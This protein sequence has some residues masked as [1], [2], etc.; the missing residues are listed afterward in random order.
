MEH[1]YQILCSATLISSF[2][3]AN[4]INNNTASRTAYSYKNKHVIKFIPGLS[5]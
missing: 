5:D 4:E 3:Y 2:C 1:R